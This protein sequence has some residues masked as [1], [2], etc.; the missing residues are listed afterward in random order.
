MHAIQ[1]LCL[2]F[3]RYFCSVVMLFYNL[4]RIFFDWTLRELTLKIIGTKPKLTYI[5]FRPPILK[6]SGEALTIAVDDIAPSV[7]HPII[8]LT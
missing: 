6:R 1:L 3:A 2:A 5:I 4:W 7:W 8:K